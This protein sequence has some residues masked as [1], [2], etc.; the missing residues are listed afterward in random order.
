MIDENNEAFKEHIAQA[1]KCLNY[2]VT[3]CEQNNYEEASV[4]YHQFLEKLN[5]LDLKPEEI[6][7]LLT[8]CEN[9]LRKV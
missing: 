2:A 7:F 8:D 1:D 6:K 4:S 5:S 9:I 3:A